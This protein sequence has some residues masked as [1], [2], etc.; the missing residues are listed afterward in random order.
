MLKVVEYQNH[1]VKIF[2][3]SDTAL[4]VITFMIVAVTL[5]M[6]ITVASLYSPINALLVVL[7]MLIVALDITR[8]A[9]DSELRKELFDGV[10]VITLVLSI[11]GIVSLMLW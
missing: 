4:A 8:T 5:I 11:I 1:M 7:A 10:L 3:R 6:R 2:E 9:K